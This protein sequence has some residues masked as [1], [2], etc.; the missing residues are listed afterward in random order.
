MSKTKKLVLASLLLAILIVVE[1]LLSVQTPILRISF[2]FVPV[3]LSALLLGPVWSALV[4]GLG[5]VIGALLFPKG[6]FFPGFTLSSLVTGLIYGLCIYNPKSNKK[7]LQGLILANVLILIFVRM[8]LTSIWVAIT[9]GR[10]WTFFVATRLTAALI[11]MPIQ[12]GIMYLLK[13]FLD[14]PINRYLMDNRDQDPQTVPE[15][16]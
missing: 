9:T 13:V 7:F 16:Q 11:M 3:T 8:G 4:A 6:V 2:A 10:A 14:K 12:V 1:R 15:A 5:D